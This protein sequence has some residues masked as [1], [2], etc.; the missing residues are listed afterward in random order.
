MN[1]NTGGTKAG[2]DED[3]AWLAGPSFNSEGIKVEADVGR[4]GDV[5]GKMRS[6]GFFGRL[7]DWLLSGC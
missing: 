6:G 1:S 3:I 2:A 5:A 7:L 4:F